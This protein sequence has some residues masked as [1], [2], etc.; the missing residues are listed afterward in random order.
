VTLRLDSSLI[1][2]AKAIARRSGKSLSGLVADYF[3]V[4]ETADKD[5]EPIPPRVRALR[6][7]LGKNKRLDEKDYKAYLL[8]KHR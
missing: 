3:A 6:G 7:V 4:L 1:R 2:H 8:R 5:D